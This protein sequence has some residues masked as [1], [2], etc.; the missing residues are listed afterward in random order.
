[1]T[2]VFNRKLTGHKSVKNLLNRIRL[3]GRQ[4]QLAKAAIF[5]LI[6]RKPVTR[7]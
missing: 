7:S 4:E 2:F 1:M 3:F 6:D 5:D